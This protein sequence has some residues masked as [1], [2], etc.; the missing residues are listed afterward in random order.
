MPVISL[1]LGVGQAN[2]AQKKEL[3]SR[4]TSDAVEITGIPVANFTIFIKELPWE[5]IGVGGKPLKDIRA[6]R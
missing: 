2:E 5:N 3:I 6:G 1:E 4:L